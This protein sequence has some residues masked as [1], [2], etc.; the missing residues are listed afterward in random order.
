M[1]N[2]SFTGH[3]PSNKNLGGYDWNSNKNKKIMLRLLAAIEGIVEELNE[4]QED[5]EINFIGGGAL[6]I[7]QMA[8]HIV[9]TA[10]KDY[11]DLWITTEIA[12]PFKNQSVKWYNRTD[13]IRYEKQLEEADLVTYVD[14]LDKYKIKGYEEGKYYPA[15][16]QKRNEYMVDKSDIVIAVWDGSN[17]GTGNCVKYARKLHKEIIIIDPKDI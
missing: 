10:I 4:S 5:N 3:R 6:G 17:G 1:I 12:V 15:K 7:D 9:E 8:I 16:M 11:Y 2:I 14:T 13:V